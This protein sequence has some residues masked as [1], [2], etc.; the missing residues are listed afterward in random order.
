MSRELRFD[1]QV[2]IVTGAGN[3]LGRS[4]ARLFARRGAKVVVNDL[5]G[6]T[7]GDG[8]S[9]RAADLVVEEIKA[10]GGEAV[11]NYDS[12]EFGDKIVQTAIDTWGR[13]DV[14]INNAGILRDKSFHKMSDEDWK[15]VF[16][17][18]VLGA[19]RVTHAAW[20]YFREQGY[21]RVIMTASAAGVYG[22]FGQANYSAAKLA[23]A[24]FS[25]TLAIEGLKRNIH[26]NTIAPLAASR[27]TKGIVPD[28]MFDAVQPEL[29]SPLVCWLTHADC[30]ETGGLFEVG[31]GFFAKLRWERSAGQTFRLGREVL[32]EQVRQS[33]DAITGFEGATHPTDITSSMT[34][35]VDNIQAGP[36]KGGSRYIDV[37]QALGYKFPTT[38]SSYDERDVSIYALGVGAGDEPLSNTNLQLVYEKHGQGF[39]VLPTFSVAPVIQSILAKAS[40]GILAPGLTFGLDR[41]LHGEQYTEVLRPMPPKA[42]LTHKSKVLDIFDKGKGALVTIETR[43]Y[44]DDGDEL[45]RNVFTAFIRGA[46]GWGG[47]RGPTEEL[48][49]PPETAPDKVTTQA[50]SPNQALLYRLSGD[51]NPLH[52]DPGFAEAFGFERPILHGLCTYGYAAR[53]VVD[54]FCGGDTQYFKSIKVRFAGSVYPGETLVTEMWKVS[55]TRIVFRCRVE[56]REGD[57]ITHAAVELYSEIPKK[58]ERA[59]PASPSE[60]ASSAPT[61]ADIFDA[62]GG[63][64][65]A[66]PDLTSSIGK[67]FQFKLSGP[68]SV[69]TLDLKS[70]GTVSSGETAAP[71]C[72]LSLSDADF[73]GMSSG[74]ADAMKLYMGGQLKIGGDIMASQKLDFLKKVE[75]PSPRAPS[76]APPTPA[77]PAS[78]A[79]FRGIGIHVEMHPELAGDVG[80]I[81]A[82]ELTN[83]DSTWTLDLKNPPGGATPGAGAKPDCTLTLSEEDFLAMTRG[84]ADP[85]KLYMDG[86]LKIGGDIMASQKLGF[87]KDVDPEKIKA[88]LARRAGSPTSA[89]AP[90]EAR[91]GAAPGIFDRLKTRLATTP[92]T[93]R[94]AIIQF[95]ITAPDDA[96]VVDLRNG[97]SVS[98]GAAERPNATLTLDDE[99]LAALVDGDAPKDLFQR[100]KLRID[101]D[102]RIAQS[103][104]FMQGL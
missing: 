89:P 64:V 37:D 78:A 55:D 69:W 71:D 93:G 82:F 8:N 97:G 33:W 3:G 25:N 53:H 72:T 23:V 24:G 40:E 77:G 42:K 74:E 39:R 79:V 34:P 90:A 46:G 68:E 73:V 2:V 98:Q 48:N 28:S 101:G 26:V 65:A 84:E 57:V 70:A 4:H 86:A 61:T 35:I 19:Y 15:L 58:A 11:A 85:M 87:L 44:E 38:S 29:V 83:P 59:A 31:G 51:W 16:L 14:V 5:G 81:F 7:T 17:V 104:D 63:Y 36:S 95:R 91:Q 75:Q 27:L 22:N 102:F 21:G 45:V 96:W 12:V 92:A 41:L 88:E 13:I 76:G 52:V 99:A 103:L 66:H 100:G 80:K 10:A 32:P 54:A 94:G 9:Q 30:E 20:P 60:P 43:S 56:E 50:I 1:D 49:A 6:S 67:V 62:I 47:D 18:H